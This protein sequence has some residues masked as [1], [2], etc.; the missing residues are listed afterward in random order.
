MMS[1][2]RTS[3]EC[4]RNTEYVEQPQIAESDS[5]GQCRDERGS[6]MSLEKEVRENGFSCET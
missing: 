3:S 2:R 5:N 4:E 6:M 1:S